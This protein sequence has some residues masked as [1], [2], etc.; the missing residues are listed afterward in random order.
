MEILS[1]I[2]IWICTIFLLRHYAILCLHTFTDNAQASGW[3]N[4]HFWWFTSW[5][6]DFPIKDRWF[7]DDS[8]IIICYLLLKIIQR[9]NLSIS[10]K[11]AKKLF[12]IRIWL[13]IRPCS[14][15]GAK[16]DKGDLQSWVA[17]LKQ[18]L[19][20]QKV[21]HC[22]CT[23]HLG[24]LAT[25]QITSFLLKHSTLFGGCVRKA[26]LIRLGNDWG[27]GRAEDGFD[28][29]GWPSLIPSLPRTLSFYSF[30]DKTWFLTISLFGWIR[31]LK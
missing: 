21:A 19:V 14:S 26:N 29:G 30:C 25:C 3:T 28:L 13:V 24:N 16:E 7:V 17:G 5:F 6:P 20:N 4:H 1:K 15:A 31:D 11:K 2:H 22:Y 27:N 10:L 12:M 8:W 23:E 9:G 18:F